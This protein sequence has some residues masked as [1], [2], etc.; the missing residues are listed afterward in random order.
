M[1]FLVPAYL[2]GGICL[3][4]FD[5]E[6]PWSEY[7]NKWAF[8]IMLEGT[9]ELHMKITKTTPGN[10]ADLIGNVRNAAIIVIILTAISVI[11]VIIAYKKAG[12]QK[13]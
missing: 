1:F 2:C 8:Q 9:G 6:I 7:G 13:S 11:T 3:Y 10:V 4:D 5:V 12:P